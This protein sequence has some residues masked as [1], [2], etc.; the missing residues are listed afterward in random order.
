MADNK[1]HPK[2]APS[3]PFSKEAA[4]EEARKAREHSEG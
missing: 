3:K 4:A 1:A 2:P